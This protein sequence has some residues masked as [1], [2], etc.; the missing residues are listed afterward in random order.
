MYELLVL[1]NHWFF[2]PDEDKSRFKGLFQLL[3]KSYDKARF[4]FGIIKSTR[5][6]KPES[7]LADLSITPD[8]D[9]F[10]TILLGPEDSFSKLK[11]RDDYER[12]FSVPSMS[13]SDS[14]DCDIPN[15]YLSHFPIDDIEKDLKV[16][17]ASPDTNIESILGRALGTV[18]VRSIPDTSDKSIKHLELTAFT[19]LRRNLGPNLLDVLINSCLLNDDMFSRLLNDRLDQ[20]STIR[21][22]LDCIR[23]HGLVE[24]YSSTCKFIRADQE[25]VRIQIN[26]NNRTIG[27]PLEEGIIATQDFHIAFMHRD[28]AVTKQ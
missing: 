18:G 24:Y 19:S 16:T 2:N 28:V 9:V 21:L 17:V 1:N 20:F 4:K 27:G 14:F 8:R 25:D 6:K 11:Q 23:E 12:N 15:E 22:H 5:I 26:E 7:A 13:L 3:N 10:L